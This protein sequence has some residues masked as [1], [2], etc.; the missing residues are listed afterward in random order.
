MMD[1]KIAG[2]NNIGRGNEISV[3]VCLLI[4]ITYQEGGS[5]QN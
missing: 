5:G 4:N 2:D 1:R 3:F